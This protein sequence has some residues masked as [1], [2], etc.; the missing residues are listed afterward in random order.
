M[1]PSIEIPLCCPFIVRSALLWAYLLSL[2]REWNLSFTFLKK[3]FRLFSFW[4]DLNWNK[5]RLF[6][7]FAPK[8]S[9]TGLTAAEGLKMSENWKTVLERKF[10]RRVEYSLQKRFQ[11]RAKYIFYCIVA[12]TWGEEFTF[13][14]LVSSKTQNQMKW[15][16]WP[17]A[18]AS[19]LGGG[20]FIFPFGSRSGYV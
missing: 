9:L 6:E 19:V 12:K 3:E 11:G 8:C 13:T 17:D 20:E 7:Y 5:W 15:L 16:G 1:Q 18:A 2:Q 10:R 4:N 14:I